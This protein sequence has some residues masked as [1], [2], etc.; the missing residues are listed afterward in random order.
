M[1]RIVAGLAVIAT[2]F[3]LSPERE[4]MNDTGSGGAP[5]QRAATRTGMDLLTRTSGAAKEAAAAAMAQAGRE[6][7]VAILTPSP[8]SAESKPEVGHKSAVASHAAS[9]DGVQLRR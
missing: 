3:I 1:F 2:L 7:A 4:S 6:A 8:R 5:E 9:L